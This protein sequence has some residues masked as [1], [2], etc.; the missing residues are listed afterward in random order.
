M[1]EHPP[2]AGYELL[3]LLARNGHLI[4][5]ARQSSCGRLVHLNVVN[6]SGD[7]GRIV[8]DGLRQQAAVLETLDHPNILRSVEA[9]GAQG[10]GFFSALEYAG[11]GCLADKIRSGPVNPTEAVCLA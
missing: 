10:Y 6:S 1:S 11:G 8:A 7:F 2:V 4:Y 5:L 3:R 9:G